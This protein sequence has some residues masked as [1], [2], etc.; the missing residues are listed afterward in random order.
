MAPDP[1]HFFPRI[2]YHVLWMQVTL[3]A[4]SNSCLPQWDV[5]VELVP[6]P[7]QPCFIVGKDVRPYNSSR[8]RLILLLS[9]TFSSDPSAQ[10]N[11]PSHLHVA[12]IQL[13]SF[14]HMKSFP[15]VQDLGGQWSSSELSVQSL[16]PSHTQCFTMHFPLRHVNSADVHVASAQNH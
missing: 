16:F 4:H 1:S 14:L 8:M 7:L 5:N 3:S 10:S 2:T 6:S 15:G 12:M 9:N 13:E 11:S